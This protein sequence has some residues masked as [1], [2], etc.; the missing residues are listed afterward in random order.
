MLI[1]QYCFCRTS[2]SSLQNKQGMMATPLYCARHLDHLLGTSISLAFLICFW[3][4]VCG[5]KGLQWV[6]LE[7]LRIG[8][9]TISTRLK[10]VMLLWPRIQCDVWILSWG[11]FLLQALWLCFPQLSD[12]NGFQWCSD[13]FGPFSCLLIVF[14][15]VDNPECLVRYS[16]PGNKERFQ[17]LNTF[18]TSSTGRHYSGI[19]MWMW[20]MCKHSFK[21]NLRWLES[22]INVKSEAVNMSNGRRGQVP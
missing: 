9:L 20:I 3:V 6:H 15:T 16:R 17:C 4:C 5:G 7:M 18:R 12:K 11:F 8:S 22:P 10:L 2:G 21:S 14:L 13:A 1:L 19:C